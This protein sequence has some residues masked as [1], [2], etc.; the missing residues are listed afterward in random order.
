MSNLSISNKIHIP[1]IVSILIG[2]VVIMFNYFFSIEEM[3]TDVY[4]T[5]DST[6]RSVYIDLLEGKK[7]IGLTNAINIADNYYAK[8]ALLENDREVA[9]AGLNSLSKTF[10]DNTEFNNIKVHIHDA[11][12]HSYLR[13]WRPEK[14]GDDLKSFRHTI[15][16]VKE[17]QK[18]LVAIELGVAGLSLRG[19][20]PIIENGE[21]LGS[22]EF[23]QGLNSIVRMAKK[24]H[25][26]DIAIVLDNK[27]LSIA[28]GLQSAKKLGNYSLAVREEITNTKF[29]SELASLNIKDIDHVLHSAN[30]FIVSEPIIDFSGD[31][32]GYALI[33]KPL[34]DVER[35]VEQSSDSLVSQVF[36]MAFV[37]LFI[38]IFLIVVIK[39]AV[40]DPIINLDKVA[41]ELAEGDADLTKR[42]PVL[43][44]DELGQASASFNAF[45]DKVEKIA[46]DAQGQA[47]HAEESAHEVEENLEKNKMTL[48]LSDS[49]IAG[50][51]E[52]SH[53]LRESMDHNVASV[54]EV[55]ELNHATGDVIKKVTA[56]TDEI[57]STI[58]NITEMISDSR[59]SSE[60]LSSNVEEIY[61]VISLIKDISDQT[62]LLAL[63]AAIEAAR[64][65]EHGRGFAVVADEVRKLAERTQKATSEVEAN[66]SVLK[67][68]STNMSENSE[69]IEEHAL[70]SSE[71]LDEFKNTLFEMVENVDKIKEDNTRIGHELFANMAKLDHMIFKNSAYS[72]VIND[73]A[74]EIKGDHTTC[75]LGKWYANEGRENFSNTSS[76]K[77]LVGPHKHVHESINKAVSL[78]KKDLIANSKEVIKLFTEAE[79]SSKELFAHLDTMVTS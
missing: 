70:S 60:Q 10:K 14:Y 50:S 1:L 29:F 23:M 77:E 44:N 24:S 12:V 26:I 48:A 47:R 20:A 46:E 63:N 66:I 21:Y 5:E 4:K 59:I 55:N 56:S 3:K 67:Q 49:M 58:S 33:G 17:T 22:V 53:N 42:L 34:Q 27:Y 37:D 18:P 54:N 32:V 15:K 2:F 76:Y 69:K 39:R 64:A 73:R 61:S 11:N 79:K 51:I 25:N 28:Q 68:N 52:N 74:E 13:A 35:I 75:N 40:A 8:K 45:L 38:L 16:K 71:K 9:I 65:G 62:N 36:I 6:L 30:Y 72:A 7:N 43:S 57:I 41:Q 78:A 31:T 19:I